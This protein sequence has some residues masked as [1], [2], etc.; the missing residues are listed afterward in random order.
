MAGGGHRRVDQQGFDS[1][2]LRWKATPATSP[3]TCAPPSPCW[4]I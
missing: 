1:R 3:A 2:T 4:R